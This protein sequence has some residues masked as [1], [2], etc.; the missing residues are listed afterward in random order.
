M[1]PKLVVVMSSDSDGDFDKISGR[2]TGPPDKFRVGHF[3]NCS[4]R[5]CPLIS[6]DFD[7]WRTRRSTMEEGVSGQKDVA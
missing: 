3:Q 6:G 2:P 4:I 1:G 5:D 7:F